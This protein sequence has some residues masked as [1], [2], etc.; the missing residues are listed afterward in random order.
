M[1]PKY[2]AQQIEGTNN[3]WM[4]T[5]NETQKKHIVFCNANANTA[6]DAVALIENKTEEDPE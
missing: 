5:E 3:G 2:T 6:E 1:E 4:L